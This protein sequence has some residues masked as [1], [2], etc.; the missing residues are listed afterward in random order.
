VR[1]KVVNRDFNKLP[2]VEF[3]NAPND[4]V[5]ERF[6]VIYISIEE[7]RSQ[8]SRQEV[9]SLVFCNTLRYIDMQ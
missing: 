2:N 7:R 5:P 4:S 3:T 9:T 1:V 8:S 6:A